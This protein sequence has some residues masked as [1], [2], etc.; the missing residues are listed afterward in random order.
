MT[1][2]NVNQVEARDVQVQAGGYGE[3]VFTGV[4]HNGKSQELDA[5]YVTVRLEPGTGAQL[6]FKMRRY[7][8]H[9]TLAQ[10]WNRGWLVKN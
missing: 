10:P 3:H 7:A 8:N 1:L 9:P 4:R 5:P 6:E 2:V